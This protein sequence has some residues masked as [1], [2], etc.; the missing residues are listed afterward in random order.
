MLLLVDTLDEAQNPALRSPIFTCASLIYLPADH[1]DKP[2]QYTGIKF[3]RNI[4]LFF[5][6]GRLASTKA[7][8]DLGCSGLR[9]A[10]RTGIA[11][12]RTLI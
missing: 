7:F 5:A 10:R 12:L 8:V 1:A 11:G 6:L 9:A 3:W 2:Y 4:K